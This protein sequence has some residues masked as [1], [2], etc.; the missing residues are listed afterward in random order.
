MIDRTELFGALRAEQPAGSA[1]STTADTISVPARVS[2]WLA[3]GPRRFEA[4]DRA[5]L[6]ALCR[7]IDVRRKVATTYAPGWKRID[8]ESTVPGP[9]LAGLVAVLLGNAGGLGRP[10]EGGSLNDGWGLKCVNSALKALDLQPD[11]PH[12]PALRAWAMERLDALR[13]NDDASGTP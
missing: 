3:D 12:A 11:A 9:V 4:H 1:S 7:Q 10:G 5:D 13:T 8:P 6:D 2:T